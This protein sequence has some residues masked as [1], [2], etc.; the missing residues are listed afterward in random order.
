MPHLYAN[1]EQTNYMELI[2]HVLL[3]TLP[4]MTDF[5]LIFQVEYL[6]SYYLQTD[7]KPPRTYGIGQG[8]FYK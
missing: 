3:L 1:K 7:C 5:L 4:V 8:I 6:L 2:W